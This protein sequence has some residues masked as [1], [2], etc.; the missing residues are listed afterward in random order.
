MSE[1]KNKYYRIICLWILSECILGGI[2][3]GLKIPISGLI[4]GS[5]SVICI[6]LIGQYAKEKNNIIYGALLVAIF[7]FILSPQSPIT[8]YI[9][10]FFQ[11]LL[12]ELLFRKN[13]ISNF[14][15]YLFSIICLLES[16]IQRIIIMTVVYGKSLWIVINETLEKFFTN[17]QFKSYSELFIFIYLCI[18]L[19]VGIGIGVLIIRLVK[20]LSAWRN[21]YEELNFSNSTKTML[22]NKAI[23]KKSFLN[24]YLIIWLILLA[25]FIVSKYSNF[26][27]E[28][29]SKIILNILFR[30]VFIIFTWIVLASPLLKYFLHKWLSKQKEKNKSD[31]EIIQYMLPITQQIVVKT[32]TYTNSLKGIRRIKLFIKIVLV[33][34]L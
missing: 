18:H 27:T 10:L 15:I 6:C 34:C 26:F 16:G 12:G 29:K 19:I 2:I 33:K 1:L 5:L 31:F 14:K 32:W 11:G 8:A 22:H 4:V 30:S 7:K 24:I 17:T 25:L 23:R 28:L 3:H 21:L 13:K 20:N 9:A